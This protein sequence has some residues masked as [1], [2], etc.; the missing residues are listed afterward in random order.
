[1]YPL[2]DCFKPFA[3]TLTVSWSSYLRPS[4]SFF[5]SSSSCLRSFLNVEGSMRENLQRDGQ[6][7]LHER[8]EHKRREG[9]EAKDVRGGPRHLPPL[10]PRELLASERLEQQPG[11]DLDLDPQQLGPHPVVRHLVLEVMPPVR[12]GVSPSAR[13]ILAHA[14]AYGPNDATYDGRLWRTRTC[15]EPRGSDA[16]GEAYQSQPWL[17]PARTVPP[18]VPRPPWTWR[19]IRPSRRRS[20]WETLGREAAAGRD[21]RRGHDGR[22]P[23]RAPRHPRLMLEAGGNG[24]RR[25]GADVADQR[26][27]REPAGGERDVNRIGPTRATIRR[28]GVDAIVHRRDAP[29][30]HLPGTEPAP[31][32]GAV[33]PRFLVSDADQSCISARAAPDRTGADPRRTRR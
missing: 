13:D 18:R 7:K 3:I 26:G 32:G 30:R 19:P 25:E 15:R 23:A 31:V 29:D 5:L 17:D 10:S 12:Y 27:R 1:M 33:S 21:G 9:D 14:T 20:S 28:E 6:Q 8:D 22:A 11:R 16:L 24:G 4:L 2:L